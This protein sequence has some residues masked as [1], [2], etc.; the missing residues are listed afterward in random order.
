[1]RRVVH[2]LGLEVVDGFKVFFLE[3]DEGLGPLQFL[4]EHPQLYLF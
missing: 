4:I 2:V 1:M 3:T